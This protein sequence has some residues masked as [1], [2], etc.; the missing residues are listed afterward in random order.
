MARQR[1]KNKRDEPHT[2]LD[3][4]P[5]DFDDVF[6]YNMTIESDSRIPLLRSVVYKKIKNAIIDR[7]AEYGSTISVD[8]SFTVEFKTDDFSQFQWAVVRE[9]LLDRGFD[10]KFSLDDGKITAMN[11]YIDRK[12]SL[13]ETI[14]DRVHEDS[15]SDNDSS[16][17]DDN[18]FKGRRQH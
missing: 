16:E 10:A 5:D 3:E 4:F 14:H 12:I 2:K 11:V 7:V 13:T 9:E 1:N 8:D 18:G 15:S 17:D 6:F